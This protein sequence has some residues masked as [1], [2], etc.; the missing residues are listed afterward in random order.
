MSGSKLYRIIPRHSLTEPFNFNLFMSDIDLTFLSPDEE[1]IPTVLKNFYI[2]K[3]FF[4]N[5]GEPEILTKSEYH[6]YKSI[7]ND[8]LEKIWR[9]LFLIRKLN[10]QQKKLDT[11]NPYEL[12]KTKRGL[13]KCYSK[14]FSINNELLLETIFLTDFHSEVITEKDF[15]FFSNFLE[16]WIEIGTRTKENSILCRDIY[17]AS[18]F[19]QILPDHFIEKNK[20]HNNSIK[21]YVHL[22]EICMSQCQLR[23]LVSK[24]DDSLNI[25]EWIERLESQLVSI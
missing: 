1:S 25:R 24:G 20:Q 7:E 12:A 11:T 10:W 9:Q 8:R 23:I 5:L 16:H 22:R 2:L 15:P 4:F 14:L 6:S 18:G 13:K 17:Q 3:K 21:R 19:L